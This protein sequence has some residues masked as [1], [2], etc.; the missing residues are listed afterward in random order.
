MKKSNIILFS[1]LIG[2]LNIMEINA[3]TTIGN[4][5]S[6]I[7]TQYGGWDGA[8]GT[9]VKDYDLRN[10]HAGQ[11]IRFYTWST[12]STNAIP[13]RMVI[14]DDGKVGIGTSAPS[15]KLDVK[16][17]TGNCNMRL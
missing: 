8:A 12:A 3:Q 17:G 4:N 7:G 6:G 14:T 1:T 10:Y 16:D 15:Y 2:V 13:E 11:A 5:A 9:T